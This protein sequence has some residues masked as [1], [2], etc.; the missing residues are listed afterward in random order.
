MTGQISRV[1]TFVVMLFAALAL[2]AQNPKLKSRD[3]LIAPE[4]AANAI[5]EGQ[6]FLIRLNDTLDTSK[7]KAGKKFSA[8]LG[9]DLQAPNGATI[10]RGTDRRALRRTR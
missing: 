3:P 10:A 2:L 7:L 5:P 6:T 1:G 4:P 8:K 9:E